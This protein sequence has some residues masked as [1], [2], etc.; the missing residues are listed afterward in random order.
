VNVASQPEQATRSARPPRLSLTA[1]ILTGLA[2]GVLVGLFFGE[3]AAGMQALADI[4]IRLMQMTVLPYL[5][6]TLIAGLGRLDAAALTRLAGRGGLLL[7]AVC[8]L[9]LAVVGV[10]PLAFPHFES[11]S[12]FS[13]TLL[14]P[15]RAISLTQLYIP[16]NPFNALANSV[17]PSV[18]LFCA[19][20][21]V[22]LIGIPHKD[23]LLAILRT[24]EQAVMQVT[25]FVILLTPIGS[26]AIAAVAAG[27]MDPATFGRLEVYF[28]TFIIAALLLAFV[29]LPLAVMAVTPF[30]FL[31]VVLVARDALLTAFVTS[32]AFIVMPILIE[33]ANALMEEHGLKTPETASTVEVLVPMAFTFPGPGSMLTLLFVPYAAWFSGQPLGLAETGTLFGTGLFVCFAPSVVALPF[34]MDLVDVAH[35][36]FQLYVAGTI[37]TNMFVALV[38]AMGLFATALI[39]V[40]AMTGFLRLKPRRIA[41]ILVVAA[42]AA[43]VAV[44][45][46]RVILAAT[47]D[48]TYSKAEALKGMQLARRAVPVTVR[49]DAPPPEPGPA[50]ALERIRA[51]GTLRVGFVDDKLPFAFFNTSRDL[52][53]MDVEVAALLARDLGVAGV[54]FV[55]TDDYAALLRL[56]TAGRIDLAMSI[57]YLVGLLPVIDYSAPYFDGV[58]GFAV[59]DKDA[60]DFATLDAIRKRGRLTLGVTIDRR[61]VEEELRENL[62][63]VELRFVLLASPKEY[64]SGL[65]PE[66]DAFAT[67]AQIGS[68]WSL[69]YPEY[70][71]VVPQPNPLKLPTGIALRKGDRDL[72][73]FVNTW[74]VIRKSSGALDLAYA[75]WVLGKGAEQRHRRWSIMHDVLGWGS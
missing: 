3:S 53:G 32:S 37:I 74:L 15:K 58:V 36:Y 70:S 8:V 23:A 54:E 55:Q 16:S 46:T 67:L 40:A 35:D 57:P 72:V 30:R 62:P 43:A 59:K 48:T 64:F 34:L 52:V 11:A 29:V 61:D 31:E 41:L 20:V 68:A 10:M 66:V 18:V 14:D 38:A 25:R 44:I 69:L 22:A 6:L 7:V 17:V 71:V 65:H 49:T 5:V 2:L 19:A 63:G 4:Y 9:A 42:A 73:D 50:P 60:D 45:G 51:H 27:T 28:A 56:L 21:G 75:Y 26:F 39:G 24:L 47:I 12:F 13:Q 1:Q 33:R